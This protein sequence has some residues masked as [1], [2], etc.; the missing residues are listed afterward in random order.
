M[1]ALE[2]YRAVEA[3]YPVLAR[4]QIGVV[5]ISSSTGFLGR[6]T[7]NAAESECY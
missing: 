7:N 6:Q 2:K 4:Q 3:A 1:A 5:Q